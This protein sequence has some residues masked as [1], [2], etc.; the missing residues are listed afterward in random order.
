M[1]IIAC[2]YKYMFFPSGKSAHDSV[3]QLSYSVKFPQKLSFIMGGLSR[4]PGNTKT[5]ENIGKKDN[6][7]KKIILKKDNIEKN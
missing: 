3:F 4:C 1:G 5:K 6:I 7:E 2:F